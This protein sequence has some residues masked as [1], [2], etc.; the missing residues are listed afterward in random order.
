MHTEIKVHSIQAQILTKL[1]FKPAARFADL[2]DQKLET[3][4]F[5]FHLQSLVKAGL[6]IKQESGGYELTNEGKEFA[7]RFDT[8]EQKLERQPKV[9]IVVV[10]TRKQKGKTQYLVQKRLK[11]PYFGFYG[12]VTGKVRWGE[13]IEECANREFLE[14]AG[15]SGDLTLTEI[16]HK[17]DYAT[18]GNLLEDKVFLRFRAEN[19]KGDL[20]ESF[21]GGQNV[22]LTKEEIAE[23]PDLFP[24]V[25]RIIESINDKHIR[26]S[27][28]KFIVEKY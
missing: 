22:W 13:T 20:I 27:E 19:C 9:S 10:G 21:E 11:N 5:N 26:F 17:M 25:V 6:V 3:D 18:D 15:L 28:K 12:F 4:H 7:N 16:W 23:L 8:E 1:L 14:E 2:N 24:D